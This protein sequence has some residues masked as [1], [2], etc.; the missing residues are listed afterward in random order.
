LSF[1]ETIPRLDAKG[2]REPEHGWG[3]AFKDSLPLQGCAVLVLDR[4]VPS[5]KHLKDELTLMGV[6]QFDVVTNPNDFF[7]FVA[8]RSYDFVFCDYNIDERRTGAVILEE[9]RTRQPANFTGSVVVLS[10][11]RSATAL[12]SMMEQEP[13][14]FLI[15]PF[16]AEE[17][18]R[19]II[20]IHARRMVFRLAQ[21][22]LNSKQYDVALAHCQE[23]LRDFPHYDKEALKFMVDVYL[24]AQRLEQADTLLKQQA[25]VASPAWVDLYLGRLCRSRGERSEAES[26]LRKA[27][28]TAPHYLIAHEELADLL[29]EAGRFEEALS[30][31]DALHTFA[32]P[33]VR[34]LRRLSELAEL[35]GYDERKKNYLNRLIEKSLGTTLVSASDFYRLA[36]HYIEANRP[37]EAAKVLSRMRVVVDG[38]EA[39]MTE[40]MMLAYG[41]GLQG[42]TD[43]ARQELEA[44]AKKQIAKGIQLSIGGKIMFM[45][46]CTRLGLAKKA[47]SLK[48]QLFKTVQDK[49]TLARIRRIEQRSLNNS[50]AA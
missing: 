15:K 7:R 25:A 37:D 30:M 38:S 14:T 36:Q 13:D 33:T 4:S 26:W 21:K 5:T 47:E 11:D 50:G 42:S 43:L 2:G 22:A 20:R 45:M 23:I 44:I 16:S 31:L 46:L 24:A 27:I 17:L 41:H 18:S 39:E 49:A 48:L 1:L 12:L 6:S 35:Q 3:K 19:R 29:V 40:G 9:L 34:R 28:S 10:G 32:S 8:E